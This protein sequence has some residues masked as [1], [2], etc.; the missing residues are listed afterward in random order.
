MAIPSRNRQISKSQRVDPEWLQDMITVK[1]YDVV[2]DPNDASRR[3]KQEIWSEDVYAAIEFR[4]GGIVS[5]EGIEYPTSDLAAVIYDD[6]EFT[7]GKVID[8]VEGD[9][10]V[11]NDVEYLVDY[12]E[13]RVYFN[14]MR[15]LMNRK[16]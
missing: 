4:P 15:I 2:Q 9:E 8:L 13:P 11:F 14:G 16:A 7:N 12:I 3:T 5:D 1:H 10:V 6:T